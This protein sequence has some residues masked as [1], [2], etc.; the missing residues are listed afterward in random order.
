MLQ[1]IHITNYAIIEDIALDFSDGLTVITGET[2]A[3][4][5]ILVG[6][7]GLLAGQ[8]SDVQALRDNS[9]KCIAEGA[10]LVKNIPDILKIFK[11]NELDYQEVTTLRREI[12]PEGKS[13]SFINDTPVTLNILKQV[14]E[15]LF[16]I[17]SQHET[18]LISEKDF[19]V[20]A[21]DAFAGQENQVSQYR[22]FYREWTNQKRL[23]EELRDKESRLRQEQDYLLFQFNELETA[24]LL[25]DEVE[26]L[27]KESD[28]LTHAD[29]IRREL[30]AACGICSRGEVNLL[31][32]LKALQQSL[33]RSVRF[34]PALH[35]LL[36][37]VDAAMIELKDI[38]GDLE[39]TFN[40]VASDPDR[41]TLI[42]DRLD[43]IN[44]LLK[45]HNL[46]T[47]G[48]LMSMKNEIQNK[49]NG[50]TSIGTD[51]EH[52]EKK[53]AKTSG[54]LHLRAGKISKGRLSAAP[55][56]TDTVH[57]LL[58]QMGMADARINISVTDIPGDLLG[59]DG[60]DLIRFLFLPN[61]G[62]E[63]KELSKIAS[64]GELSRLMLAI[65]ASVARSM[66]LPTLILDE[67]DSGVSGEVAGKAGNIMKDMAASLQVIAI[68][69]LPQIASKGDRH[70]R[71]FKKSDQKTTRTFVSELSGDE[72]IYELAKML[73]GEK[74]SDAAVENARVLLS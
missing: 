18:L 10:F 68:T 45:K 70:Y 53:I 30:G 56:L 62:G 14:S 51:I 5:S 43:L 22:E 37:R 26:N 1:S 39:N 47:T 59:K 28:E 2:G 17:H 27:E 65:K 25:P 20:L 13:R 73:S 42:N 38:S 69:H 11:E 67:V 57:K 12:S 74:V 36:S 54:E 33:T 61:K 72:R 49:I 8:R 71:V 15:N 63:F 55:R 40:S 66:A 9:K 60:K 16:D 44:R 7:L 41:L 23:L 32:Q 58:R 19:Q 34:K 48:D 29:E 24:N 6:A 4:K 50:I 52:L 21:L 35:D 46:R 3:G 64:G 31:V